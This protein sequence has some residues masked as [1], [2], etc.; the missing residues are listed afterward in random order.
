MSV[1]YFALFLSLVLGV[2][3]ADEPAWR[4]GL[5]DPALGPHP[6]L[7]PVCLEYKLSWNGTLDA[8]QIMFVFG[9]PDPTQPDEYVVRA[10]GGSRGVARKMFDYRHDFSSRLDPTTLRPRSFSGTET[11]DDKKTTTHNTYTADGVAIKQT[12]TVLATGR[13]FSGGHEFKFAPVFDLFS[14]ML[15][16][17]SKPLATG[18]KLSLVVHPFASPC[19]LDA[20]VVARE[21]HDGHDAIRLD[22]RLQRITPELTLQPY[23]KLKQASLWLSDD[24]DRF[25]LDLRTAVFIGDVRM[26]LERSTPLP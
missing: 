26:T 18:D 8:G 21:P 2:A 5:T 19:L 12:V 15:F 3:A 16:I 22:I 25:P 9:K 13:E 24:A 7:A 20:T 17:R 6:R 23:E 10:I 14:A 1:R 11:G 4:K